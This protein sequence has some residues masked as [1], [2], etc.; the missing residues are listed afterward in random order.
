VALFVFA[1]L[2]ESGLYL[3]RRGLPS[4]EWQIVFD[5]RPAPTVQ[6]LDLGA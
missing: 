5:E 6:T 3:Y 1:A 4:E 2:C